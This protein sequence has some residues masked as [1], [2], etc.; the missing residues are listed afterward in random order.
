MAVQAL[1]TRIL[2]LVDPAVSFI[3]PKSASKK[4]RIIVLDA[5]VSRD[6]Y[7]AQVNNGRES[8]RLG[9]KGPQT[10]IYVARTRRALA[11]LW[12]ST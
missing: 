12:T 4:H 2:E 3:C 7:L 10:W 5:Y 11:L 6:R 1:L 9:C 8:R